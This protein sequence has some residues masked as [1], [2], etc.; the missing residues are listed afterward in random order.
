[1]QNV[2]STSRLEKAGQA[3]RTAKTKKESSGTDGNFSKMLEDQ[4]SL[5]GKEKVSEEELFSAVARERVFTLKGKDA[6]KEYDK[7]ID[8][9]RPTARSYETLT[10]NIL[11][12]LVSSK[13]LSSDEANKVYSQ[14]FAAAQLDHRTGL[15]FDGEG[16]TKAVETTAKAI[17][18]AKAAIDAMNSGGSTQNRDR[19]EVENI[20]VTTVTRLRRDGQM[21]GRGG[22]KYTAFSNDDGNMVVKAPGALTGNIERVEVR[23]SSGRVLDTAKSSLSAASNKNEQ[24]RFKKSG[25][26]YPS[27]ISINFVLKTGG[28]EA[29]MIND[30]SLEWD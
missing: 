12:Q 22:F 16:D 28:I 8:K 10:K 4:L 7:L 11:N 9:G 13:K 30:S 14:S 29:F 26:E 24:A 20:A 2:T 25:S 6:A 18:K 1:V 19:N 17:E 3:D 23:D 27:T 15:L 21:D 5:L